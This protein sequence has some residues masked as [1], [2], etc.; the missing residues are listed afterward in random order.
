[1]RWYNKL[2]IIY[3]IY[4]QRIFVTLLVFVMCLVSFYMIDKVLTDYI[5]S[6]YAIWQAENQMG[7]EPDNGFYV[8]IYE[9]GD[10]SQ[11]YRMIK[12]YLNKQEVVE[13][14]GFVRYTA[15]F[16]KQLG[17]SFTVPTDE[18]AGFMFVI[19]EKDVLSLGNHKLS[20]KQQEIVDNHS[21]DYAP[22]FLGS[23]YKGKVKEGTLLGFDPHMETAEFYVAGFLEKDAAWPHD[24][25]LFGH[26]FGELD[27]YN[28]N[29]GALLV[30]DDLTPYCSLGG[31]M[32][33]CVTKEGCYEQAKTGVMRFAMENNLNIKVSNYGE[34]IAQEKAKSNIMDDDTLVAAVTLTILAVISISAS[35][36]IYCLVNKVQYGIM[37]ANGLTRG[38][39]I[40]IITMQNAITIIVAGVAA[41]FIRQHEIFGVGNAGMS[42]E[43]LVN[44]VETIYRQLYVAHDL[45]MPVILFVA[46]AV[47][48]FTA[49]VM[50]VH[51]IR[52]TPL[53]EMISQRS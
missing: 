5:S 42:K 38:N 15:L 10:Q 34:E 36:I 43:E 32:V 37:L 20:E 47:M 50:P 23:S 51:I 1:M 16:R 30:T 39:I 45:Y 11:G 12:D 6:R 28:L 25:G 14:A 48:L 2:K 41:W 4:S 13:G 35:S 27:G 24:Q 31:Y 46:G 53:P 40:W 52:K 19:V 18:Y 9:G 44:G 33:Y 17:E 22:I 21:G 8:Q 3:R 29:E 26:S 7:C 49:S